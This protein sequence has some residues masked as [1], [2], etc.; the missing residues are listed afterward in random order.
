MKQT[1]HLIF[2]I[3]LLSVFSVGCERMSQL[4]NQRK[5]IIL[6]RTEQ[7]I[8]TEVNRFAFDLFGQIA[9]EDE[10]F[11]I[12]PLSAS[13][14]LSMTANGTAGATA[15]EMKKILGFEDFSYKDM[16]GFFR[17]M[18]RELTE[19][20]RL[21][22]IGIANSIWIREGFPVRDSFKQLVRTWY[23]AM[24]EELDFSSPL[25]LETINNWCADQTKGKIDKIIDE[26]PPQM[27]MYLINALY[28]KGTWTKSFDQT[29]SYRADFYP[30]QG[31]S[32]LVDYMIQTE[33]FPYTETE[34]ARL[35]ELP[36]GNQA[37]SMVLVLPKP[38][39]HTDRVI[40]EEMNLQTWKGIVEKMKQSDRKLTISMPKFKY[41]YEKDL[42][43]TLQA[44][45]MELPFIEGAAD[46]SN[47]SP[48]TGLYIGLVK[49][50][51]YVEINEKG[52]EA[53]AVTVVGI[54]KSSGPD[55]PLQ[56][57]VNRSFIYII[58]E[59]STGSILFMGKVS[60]FEQDP[61]Q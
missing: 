29:L 34:Y 58:K 57:N 33:T 39:N 20:D 7:A 48:I 24:I 53:A 22:E 23:L 14:A 56:F 44:M 50:K 59:K 19:A 13:L 37:F 36:Y 9:T 15:D 17:T 40:K 18:T 27:L 11:F 2:T 41:E 52:T 45:G 6:T 49:Q 47:L 1:V 42:I 54:E 12:S 38:G 61:V 51:T 43:P 3:L 30:D 46:F 16:N 8:S 32:Q 60:F 31:A 25:A 55:D 4:A 5:D 28:F 10:N 21:T 35:A 26:I